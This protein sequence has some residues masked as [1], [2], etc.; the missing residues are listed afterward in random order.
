M[1]GLTFMAVLGKYG[2]FHISSGHLCLGWVSFTIIG[3]DIELTLESLVKENKKLMNFSRHN[4]W[5]LRDLRDN[6]KCDKGPFGSH[7]Y[8]CRK[9]AAAR[10]LKYL[11]DNR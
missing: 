1:N 8:H 3:Q 2:G 9:C 4:E 6:Y 10:E 11:E 7:A 5:R